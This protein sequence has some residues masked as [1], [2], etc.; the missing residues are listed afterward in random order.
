MSE[1]PASWGDLVAPSK[2]QLLIRGAKIKSQ[3]YP[4]PEPVYFAKILS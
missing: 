4:I 2:F 1:E 3:H